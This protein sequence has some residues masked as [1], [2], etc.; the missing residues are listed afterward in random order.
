MK[1]IIIVFAVFIGLLFLQSCSTDDVESPV[2][3]ES[4]ANPYTDAMM[5]RD[6]ISRD[7]EEID[8]PN[9]PP[10]KP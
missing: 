2:R 6:T 1:T 4:V 7:E 5:M 3:N 8:P 10:V 9:L